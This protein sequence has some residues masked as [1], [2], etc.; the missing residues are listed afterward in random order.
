MDVWPVAS[1]GGDEQTER[2]GLDHGWKKF[3]HGPADGVIVTSSSALQ[4]LMGVS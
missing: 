1:C 2:E 4:G 3:R